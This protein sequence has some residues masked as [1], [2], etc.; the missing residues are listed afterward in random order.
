VFGG[1]VNVENHCEKARADKA[2]ELMT[3]MTKKRK[4]RQ[5]KRKNR[6]FSNNY[7]Y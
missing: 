1:F 3:K 5:L 7:F 4:L 2:S 6:P